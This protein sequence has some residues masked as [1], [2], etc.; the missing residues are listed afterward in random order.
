[1][2]SVAPDPGRDLRPTAG[3]V[4]TLRGALDA[5]LAGRLEEAT[6][7]YQAALEAS[8]NCFDALHM[9]GVVRLQQGNA[10]SACALLLAALQQ[11][12]DDARALL[13][14]LG[15]ALAAVIRERAPTDSRPP[16]APRPR[17]A[18]VE[19][20]QLPALS[21]DPP[22]VSIVAPSYNHARYVKEALASVLAQSYAN[23]ELIVIDDGST[24][25]SPAIIEDLLA[26]ARIPAR[27]IARENRG[28][29]ATINE[30][31]TLASGHYIGIINTDDR[32]AP[33]RVE[34]LVR[35]LL[36]TGAPWGFTAV[37][38][39]DEAGTSLPRGHSA[40]V[41]RL[42]Q[43]ADDCLRADSSLVAF[44][45]ANPV[46]TSGNLLFEKP[47]WE[48]V[49]GF[50]DYRYNHDWAFCLALGSLADP[51]IL[52]EPLYGYRLHGRN[53]INENAERALREADALLTAWH[54][55]LARE[56]QDEPSKMPRARDHRQSIEL[57]TLAGGA[58]HL[59][60]RER[61]VDYARNLG[62][63]PITGSSATG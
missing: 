40:A 45:T 42:R 37:E 61:L 23:L 21:E 46:I 52:A 12:P 26:S 34:L 55:Q 58:G 25:D 50:A 2:T 44:T 43:A 53:T 49:G 10:E 36:H 18:G 11:A 63:A 41:E 28:A 19:R 39:I 31:V 20:R 1:M 62:L 51:C 22:L 29:H 17:S 24:D 35:A 6:R 47:L 56:P 9:L 48:A 27:L 13:K 54:R 15:L 59:L 8:P 16:P 38:P 3:L 30:G 60:G 33:E 5:Q 32:Y 57:A 14:N 7:L 4:K